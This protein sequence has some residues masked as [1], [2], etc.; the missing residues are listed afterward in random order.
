MLT[1]NLEVRAAIYISN[2]TWKNSFAQQPWETGRHWD[3]EIF[4]LYV[5][6][7]FYS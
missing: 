1:G 7:N 4:E 3:M 5:A 2:I 6:I